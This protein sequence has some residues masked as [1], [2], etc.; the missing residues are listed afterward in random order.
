[1]IISTS[2]DHN[3]YMV[4]EE[5]FRDNTQGHFV[6]DFDEQM[7]YQALLLAERVLSRDYSVKCG[8]QK[9]YI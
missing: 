4:V 2:K 5:L 3:T 6:I 9:H 1:M 7:F 8:L